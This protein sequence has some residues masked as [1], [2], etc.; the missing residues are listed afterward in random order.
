MQCDVDVTALECDRSALSVHVVTRPEVDWRAAGRGSNVRHAVETEAE[1][2]IS[3][4]VFRV[5]S[6]RIVI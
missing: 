3:K 2:W 1:P 5:K 4:Q 6:V